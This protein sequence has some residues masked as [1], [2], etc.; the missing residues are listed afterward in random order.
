MTQPGGLERRLSAKDLD[1]EG[2]VIEPSINSIESSINSIE[3]SIESVES[4]IYS[5]I[6]RLGPVSRGG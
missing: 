4:S 3:S 6:T 1:G 2:F 5:W